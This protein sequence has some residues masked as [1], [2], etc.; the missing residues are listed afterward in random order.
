[1][2]I[3]LSLKSA[4]GHNRRLFVLEQ[5]TTVLLRVVLD[6]DFVESSWYT[7]YFSSVAKRKEVGDNFVQYVE[8]LRSEKLV[9]TSFYFLLFSVNFATCL[10][11][12]TYP[13]RNFRSEC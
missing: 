3:F 7:Y 9:G 6:T 5:G 1:M 4:S 11:M 10:R 12:S 8:R 13:F 2:R